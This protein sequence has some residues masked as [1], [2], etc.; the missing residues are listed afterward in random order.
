M[1]TSV[2]SSN[3]CISLKFGHRRRHPCHRKRKNCQQN[4][5]LLN[6]IRSLTVPGEPW[7]FFSRT[8][9]APALALN[10]EDVKNSSEQSKHSLI[11]TLDLT[12]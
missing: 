6:V 4:S 10:L 9:L 8:T 1:T 12:S 11:A 7:V 5:E 2:A 3:I